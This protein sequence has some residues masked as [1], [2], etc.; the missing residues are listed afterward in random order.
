MLTDRS[1]R[2]SLARACCSRSARVSQR[3]TAAQNFARLERSSHTANCNAN[4]N[5]FW[6][7]SIKNAET[8]RWH[9]LRECQTTPGNFELYMVRWKTALRLWSPRHRAET[10]ES[11]CAA[12]A[13]VAGPRPGRSLGL[14]QPGGRS[15][16]RC[17][18]SKQ[19]VSKVP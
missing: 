8:K 5:C 2:A 6:N 13:A 16:K 18:H 12:P 1:L 15:N 19:S 14:S 4:A 11:Q 17:K 10:D 3:G 9:F 7:L